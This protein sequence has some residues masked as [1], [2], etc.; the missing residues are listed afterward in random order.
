LYGPV[1]NLNPA[2]VNHKQSRT[3]E[4]AILLRF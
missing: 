3:L 2:S 1:I 4:A